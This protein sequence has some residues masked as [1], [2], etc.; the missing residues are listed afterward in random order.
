MKYGALKRLELFSALA[1]PSQKEVSL[2]WLHKSFQF[3]NIKKGTVSL[4]IDEEQHTARTLRRI[5]LFKAARSGL[6]AQAQCEFI[7]NVRHRQAAMP[8]GQHEVK[9]PCGCSLGLGAGVKW[10]GGWTLAL[11]A[12][13]GGWEEEIRAQLPTGTTAAA[14][15]DGRA[16]GD[17]GPTR[18]LTAIQIRGLYAN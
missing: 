8:G 10:V 3:K 4:E 5:A 17:E 6:W 14:A 16:G 2:A 11:A 13:R 7:S 12:A 15:A 9:Q 18:V 1:S